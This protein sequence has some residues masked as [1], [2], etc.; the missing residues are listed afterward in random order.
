MNH[1]IPPIIALV[2]L[3]TSAFVLLLIYKPQR[4]RDNRCT[5]APINMEKTVRS[6]ADIT[7][8]FDKDED[9]HQ[10]RPED[11]LFEQQTTDAIRSGNLALVFEPFI[12][13]GPIK[14]G[15]SKHVVEQLEAVISGLY[16]CYYSNGRLDAFSIAPEEA[17][18]IVF[19]GQD[20]L[21]MDKLEAALFLARQSNKYGQAQGGSLYFMDLGCAILQFETPIR[22]FLFFARD[23]DTGEP[24]CGMSPESIQSYYETQMEDQINE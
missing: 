18:H 20:I 14:F 12:G 8:N 6:S 21:M 1:C 13:L 23:Y 17:G 4:S 7:K 11:L 2:F 10:T 19:A 22:E 9:A 24:L 15:M 3:V 16:G 5:A